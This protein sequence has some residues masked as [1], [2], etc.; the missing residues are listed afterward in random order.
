MP[1][2]LN[3][4]TWYSWLCS[5][6]SSAL[7]TLCLY[8]LFSQLEFLVYATC[9]NQTIL[10]PFACRFVCCWPKVSRSQS[11]PRTHYLANLWITFN[12]LIL[13]TP[14]PSAGIDVPQHSLYGAVNQTQRLV[15]VKH[16]STNWV[17]SPAILSEFMGFS[18]E[19]ED[20]SGLKMNSWMDE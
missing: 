7:S 20:H 10:Y 18:V 15:N 3:S 13:L 11:W 8:Y 14:S 17:T 19:L 2:L 1:H 16:Y 9:L 6:F 5:C 4:T 12:F